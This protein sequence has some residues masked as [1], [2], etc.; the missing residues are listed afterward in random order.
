MFSHGIEFGVSKAGSR[1][2]REA[3]NA[4]LQAVGQNN[5]ELRLAG[6][7]QALRISQR[8]AITTPLVNPSPLGGQ[9]RIVVYTTFLVDGSLFYYLTIVPERRSAGVSGDIPAHRAVDSADGSALNLSIVERR[10]TTTS[11]ERRTSD[12]RRATNHASDHASI[13]KPASSRQSFGSS[14]SALIR[15]TAAASNDSRRSGSCAMI[16]SFFAS[17]NVPYT[18]L[19]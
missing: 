3:T 17:G 1:D 16:S 8:S 15:Y 10:A 12:E 4:W 11:E 2:L 7:Q 5:P 6:S 9:E 19:R 13:G 18:R 14:L